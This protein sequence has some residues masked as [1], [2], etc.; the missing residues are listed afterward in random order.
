MYCNDN[1]K[2]TPFIKATTM[3]CQGLKGAGSRWVIIA[4]G[5]QDN[6]FPCNKNDILIVPHARGN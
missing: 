6:R 4:K 3:L 1:Y 2:G 5:K